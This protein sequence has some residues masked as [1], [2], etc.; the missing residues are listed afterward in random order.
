MSDRPKKR[1]T[2]QRGLRPHERTTAP[3]RERVSAV[4]RR[5]VAPPV[6]SL[7]RPPTLPRP[8]TL[9]R[10]STQDVVPTDDSPLALLEAQVLRA[11]AALERERSARAA[12]SMESREL[13]ARIARSDRRARVAEES[14]ERTISALAAQKKIVAEL[15]ADLARLWRELASARPELA[16]TPQPRREDKTP[17]E[18]RRSV[19]P[20]D[21]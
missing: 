9:Q 7:Q 13:L 10:P 8:H 6:A 12:E 18:R 11:E 17:S 21:A 16:A 3:E 20:R 19:R 15:E 2:S 5:S 4:P 1:I 14:L